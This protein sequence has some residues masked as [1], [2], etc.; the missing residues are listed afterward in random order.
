[1]ETLTQANQPVPDFLSK[2]GGG[3][4]SSGGSRANRDIRN[5]MPRFRQTFG[6]GGFE[7]ED[8]G[9]MQ[10]AQNVEQTESW[11]GGG[12]GNDGW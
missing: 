5:N 12:G 9:F 6:R 8:D 10:S 3:G 2:D 4:F 7:E 11:Q 1:M